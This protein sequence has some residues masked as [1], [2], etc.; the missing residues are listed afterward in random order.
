MKMDINEL[1]N[2]VA[3]LCIELSEIENNKQ[4]I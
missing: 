2:F 3:A 1:N 4:E